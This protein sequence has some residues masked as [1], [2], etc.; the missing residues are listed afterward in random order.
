MVTLRNFTGKDAQV[1]QQFAFH[2]LSIEQ[3]ENVIAEWDKKSTSESV[4]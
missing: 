4:F 3:I 1:L 2:D